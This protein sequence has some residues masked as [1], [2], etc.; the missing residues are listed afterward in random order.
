MLSD[1]DTKSIEAPKNHA[2]KKTARY[3]EQDAEKVNEYLEKIE[4]IPKE[5]IIYID[6]TG[7]DKFLY[8]KYARAPK[9]EKIYE[10]VKGKKF[11]RLSIVAG[12]AGNKIIAPLQYK[13]TMTSIFFEAWFEKHLIP[14]LAPGTVI[15]MD[16][17][18]FHRKKRLHELAEEYNVKIVF[19]PP[20]SPELNPIEHFWY[21]LKKKVCDL[22]KFSKNLDEAIFSI[23]KVL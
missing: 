19:L 11:E 10:R 1:C 15:V 20:Y 8:R 13:G 23:F 7:I 6:E 22:L 12:L 2:K 17:A 4:D 14:G 16:N 21:W 18:S 3:Y 9:G 5:K